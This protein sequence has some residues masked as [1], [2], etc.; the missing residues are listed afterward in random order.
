MKH[1]IDT[2][3]PKRKPRTRKDMVAF[4]ENHF[5]YSTM[6]SWNR[7]TSYA[8]NVKLHRISFPD[9][10]TADAAHEWLQHED[11]EVG[12]MW[13]TRQILQ[14]FAER[15]GYSWQI[16]FNG[17]S[18]GYLVLYSGGRK[19]LDY[20]SRCTCCGQ[21]NYKEVL[22]VSDHVQPGTSE[23]RLF[24]CLLDNPSM[25]VAEV[26]QQNHLLGLGFFP[27]EFQALIDRFGFLWRLVPQTHTLNARCGQCGKMARVNL[28]GPIY[29][30]Y[31]DHTG[32][33]H[34]EDFEAW[35]TDR[36]KDRVDLL[37]DFHQTVQKAVTAFV[38][39][40]NIAGPPVQEEEGV[41]EAE[42]AYA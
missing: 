5:R 1:V 23:E 13:E 37:M 15:H 10:A 12:A 20:K 9:S 24:R 2:G 17:R 6:N 31:V 32:V 34:G 35:E 38:W 28:D 42:V 29:R 11:V 3:C 22:I 8:I 40:V 36:L 26:V 21:L 14:A 16:G 7:E 27:E 18:S 4:L 30:D 41:E 33:D 39:T 19:R 25:P